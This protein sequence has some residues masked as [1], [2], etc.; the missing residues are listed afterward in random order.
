[1]PSRM[2]RPLPPKRARGRWCTS[3]ASILSEFAVVL[4]PEEPLDGAA[5][6][7]RRHGRPARCPCGLCSSRAADN[8]R[9]ARRRPC[10]WR[11][12]RRRAY[13]LAGRCSRDR[14]AR[15]ARVR[16]H[17]S[18][19]SPW[20]S[21]AGLRPLATALD[22]EGFDDAGFGPAGRKLCPPPDGGHGCLAGQRVRHGDK[23]LS[24]APEPARRARCLRSTARAIC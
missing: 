9:L 4:E 8:H 21:D 6:L 18:A 19:R 11:V 7:L 23:N 22:E 14:A 15:L 5:R 13:G 16:R 12:D 2:P 1:M 10:R 20:A 24:G 17:A 3:A